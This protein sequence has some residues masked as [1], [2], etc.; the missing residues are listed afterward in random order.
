LVSAHPCLFKI[1]SIN[2]EKININI[3]IIFFKKKKPKKKK[4]KN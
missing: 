3:F 2:N 4:K 1:I